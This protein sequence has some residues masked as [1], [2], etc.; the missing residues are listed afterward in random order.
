MPE[1][2]KRRD[3]PQRR[4]VLEELQKLTS[5]PTAADL[6][7]IVRKRLPSISLGTVYRNLELLS[8]MG[9]IQK[10]ELGGTEARFDGNSGRHHHVQCLEC[11]RVGDLH[12]MADELPIVVPK[13]QNDFTILGHSLVFYGLCRQC[14]SKGTK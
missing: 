12:G 11:G 2:K 3:T 1:S 4:V 6:Y 8:R 10:L 9:I 13:E 14:K 5:H 7:E